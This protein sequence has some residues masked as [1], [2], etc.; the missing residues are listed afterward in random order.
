MPDQFDIFISYSHL[1]GRKIDQFVSVMEAFGYTV[2]RDNDGI[3]L[4]E[5]IRRKV[6]EAQDAALIHCFWVTDN[7]KA[8]RFCQ[9][10]LDESY[11]R[12]GHWV[13]VVDGTDPPGMFAGRKYVK[14]DG[15]MPE[16]C[17]AFHKELRKSSS[18]RASE[19]LA[20]IRTQANCGERRPRPAQDGHAV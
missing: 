20:L 10:E 19:H 18:A 11:S 9:D 13:N 16:T 6:K 2:W 12:P 7:W 1:D 3:G 15:D 14:H 8:S 17:C 4:G 5:S